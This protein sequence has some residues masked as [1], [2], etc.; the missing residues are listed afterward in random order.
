MMWSPIHIFNCIFVMTHVVNVQDIPCFTLEEQFHKFLIE[1]NAAFDPP[2]VTTDNIMLL[3]ALH[4]TRELS[5][6]DC[7]L[8][9][10]SLPSF[11]HLTNLLLD[12]SGTSSA[13]TDVYDAACI[14]G[15]GVAETLAAALSS[16]H[17]LQRLAL[18]WPMHGVVPI[19]AALPAL[20]SLQDFSLS[21]PKPG[22]STLGVSIVARGL[23]IVTGLQRYAPHL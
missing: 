19:A 13:H 2:T 22:L 9:T 6:T 20:E 5:D 23:P 8:L 4:I 15:G 1:V 17:W 21:G 14:D 18:R 11:P 7:K 3:K 16:M 10:S 12:V